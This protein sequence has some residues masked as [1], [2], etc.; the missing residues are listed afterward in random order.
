MLILQHLPEQCFN[1]CFYAFV[2]SLAVFLIALHYFKINITWE[3]RD[4]GNRGT[5]VGY[6]AIKFTL[7]DILPVPAG[8]IQ[9]LLKWLPK[10]RAKEHCLFGVH[11]VPLGC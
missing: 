5:R 2:C 10:G 3:G 7:D 9:Q 11:L 1:V 6:N 8:L 4:L